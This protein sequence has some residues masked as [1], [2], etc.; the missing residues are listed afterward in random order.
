MSNEGIRKTVQ[1]LRNMGQTTEILKKAAQTHSFPSYM[2]PLNDIPLVKPPSQEE[3]HGYESATALL[4]RLAARIRYWRQEINEDE[5]PVVHALLSGDVPV[6]NVHKLFEESHN[7]ITVIGEAEGKPY[8][9]LTHQSNL[10]LLCF[11][12]TVE[13]E[14]AR[15]CIGFHINGE[16][17]EE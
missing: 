17:F 4:Q 16:S 11:T 2:A 1:G 14:E 9:Y 6:L 15:Y 5:Q 12:E 3:V 10:Q 7:G 8:M 13:N